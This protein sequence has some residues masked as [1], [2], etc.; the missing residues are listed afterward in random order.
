MGEFLCH[1][2]LTIVAQFASVLEV[3]Q[4]RQVSPALRR[5]V[6][7]CRTDVPTGEQLRAAEAEWISVTIQ[8][9]C[10]GPEWLHE[11]DAEQALSQLSN[12][13]EAASP[14]GNGT[15]LIASVPPVLAR[16]IVMLNELDDSRLVVRAAGSV[17][18]RCFLRPSEQECEAPSDIPHRL[19]NFPGM[20]FVPQDAERRLQILVEQMVCI[21]EDE[22]DRVAATRGTSGLRVRAVI[23]DV[24]Q[25]SPI[26]ASIS[27]ER[28]RRAPH[29]YHQRGSF[30]GPFVIED[31]SKL[32]CGLPQHWIWDFNVFALHIRP[33][34]DVYGFHFAQSHS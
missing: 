6:L 9:D 29:L 26:G 5:V 4:L 33:S 18:G 1:D 22:F 10:P 34:G 8:Q 27:H 25:G 3:V 19:T 24:L 15:T 16:W 2:V 11:D 30:V 28:R 7:E 32:R 13:C 23:E 14:I 31:R 17:L 12:L 20:V 21:T